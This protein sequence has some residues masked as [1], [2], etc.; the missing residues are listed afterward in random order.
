MKAIFEQW[1]RH[2]LVLRGLSDKTVQAYQTKVRE[3]LKW[4]DL[5][6]PSELDDVIRI[7]IEKFLEYLFYERGNVNQVRLT[8]LGAISTFWRFL[9]YEGIVTFD[10]TSGIPKPK[11]HRKFIQAFTKEERLRIFR[12]VDIWSEKGLRDTCILIVFCFCGLRVGEVCSLRI[13]DIVDSGEHIDIQIPEDIGKQG[14][15]RVVD[16]WKAPSAFLRQ[17]IGIRLSHGASGKDR[18]FVTYRKGDFVVGNPLTEK[19]VD[20][21][22]KRLVEKA[23]I[24]KARAY[25]HMF[26]AS[27]GGDLRYIDGFDIAAIAERLGHKNISTTDRYLPQRGRIS[28]KYRS[29]REY[30]LEWERLWSV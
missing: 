30:W 5:K 11:V 4:R 26:R 18:V 27:H 1:E 3:F 7:D 2:M 8:K 10:V 21:L 22:I 28:R 15:S 13:N 6:D 23:N 29:L 12:Q 20:R 14:S 9:L 16:L 25:S 17:W 24:R 19:D